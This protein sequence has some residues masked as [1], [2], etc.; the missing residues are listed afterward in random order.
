MFQYHYVYHV[1]K[2]KEIFTLKT[3][4]TTMFF[5]GNSGLLKLEI[6]KMLPM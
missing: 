2:G 4:N 5:N 1:R 6:A 3:L